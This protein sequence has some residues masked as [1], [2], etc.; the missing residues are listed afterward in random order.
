[1]PT[2]SSWKHAT[3]LPLT[4]SSLRNRRARPI[5]STGPPPP[6]HDLIV[7]GTLT[8][9]AT[10]VYEEAGI[11]NGQPYY[12]RTD[13]AY[14]IW[15][16]TFGDPLNYQW[17]ITDTLGV[18]GMFYWQKWTPTYEPPTGIYAPGGFA[19]GTATVAAA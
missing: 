19:Y 9:D 14:F 13:S 18:G 11:F 3:G 4:S 1:M 17:L 6:A 12:Q 15:V 16:L 7:T 2:R 5:P 8:P 10:G